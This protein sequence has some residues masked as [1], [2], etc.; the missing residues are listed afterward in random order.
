MKNRI[1]VLSLVMCLVGMMGISAQAGGGKGGGKNSV[2]VLNGNSFDVEDG[3][4]RIW[5]LTEDDEVPQTK[6]DAEAL[7][8]RN[9]TANSI[10]GFYDLDDGDYI[11]VAAYE[12]AYQSLPDDFELEPGVTY[13]F[14]P[15]ELEGGMC[16][17][18]TVK[19][20]EEGPPTISEGFD[21]SGN[22]PGPGDEG[23]G[24]GPPPGPGM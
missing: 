6:A 19:T 15:I 11:L 14:Q 5:L 9:L 20:S 23:P 16:A 8:G 18:F 2:E 24:N 10:N 21:F 3:D 13:S 4:I 22:L 12:S 1:W 17:K 7:G